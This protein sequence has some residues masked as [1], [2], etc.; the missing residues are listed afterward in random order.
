MKLRK[1]ANE[2]K[3][4]GNATAFLEDQ[5]HTNNTPWP[6]KKNKLQAYFE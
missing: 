5:T 2:K 6:N 1:T 3:P 4:K